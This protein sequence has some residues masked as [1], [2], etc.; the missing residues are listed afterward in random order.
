MFAW[1][2]ALNGR[3]QARRVAEHEERPNQEDQEAKEKV[4]GADDERECVPRCHALQLTVEVLKVRTDE[5]VVKIAQAGRVEGIRDRLARVREER[6]PGLL[7]VV[8]VVDDSRHEQ[9]AATENDRKNS[10][11]YHERRRGARE[12]KSRLKCTHD[13]LQYIRQNGGPDERLNDVSDA[14]DQGQSS[15]HE[16]RD[17]ESNGEE[18]EQRIDRDRVLDLDEGDAPNRGDEDK[19]EERHKR[20]LDLAPVSEPA[21]GLEDD[22]VSVDRNDVDAAHMTRPRLGQILVEAGL[23]TEEQLEAALEDQT[24]TGRRLG[25]IVVERG[26]MSGP[27]LANALA[28]QHGGVVRTEYGIA[29]GLG[30]TT[31]TPRPVEPDAGPPATADAAPAATDAPQEANLAPDTDAPAVPDADV[32]DAPAPATQSLSLLHVLEDWSGLIEDLKTKVAVLE[33]ELEAVRAERDAAAKAELEAAKAELEAAREELAPAKAEAEISKSQLEATT[34]TLE[35]A[36]KDLDTARAEA[37]EAKAQL[38]ETASRVHEL[39]RQAVEPP[40][41]VEAPAPVETAPVDEAPAPAEAPAPVE[42]PAPVAVVSEVQTHNPAEAVNGEHAA[43]VPETHLMSVPTENGFV[44]LERPGPTP[45]VGTQVRFEEEPDTTYVVAK[46]NA[47]SA[48]NPR[49]CAFLERV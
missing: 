11:E 18:R 44:L 38:A 16:A 37:R 17:R 33:T 19:C 43:A 4:A 9:A 20:S 30:S 2:V 27:A 6:W 29:T 12:A 13:R 23:L 15:E 31:S 47:A 10:E 42:T 26:Y 39:E 45:P 34:A 36:R 46:V 8:R 48:L 7:K 22:P 14:P 1:H 28:T 24:R 21:A 3:E 40:P 49:P 32:P 35:A 25:E 41:P 5:R